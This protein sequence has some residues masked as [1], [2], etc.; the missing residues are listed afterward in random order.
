MN[1]KK[2]NCSIIR[3]LLACLSRKLF[4]IFHIKYNFLLYHLFLHFIFT[5]SQ[6]RLI[7]LF[8]TFCIFE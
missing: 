1:N 5:A 7:I 4:S 8:C 3:L 2:S 6:I